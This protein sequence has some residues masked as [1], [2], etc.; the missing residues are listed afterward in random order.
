MSPDKKSFCYAPWHS[1]Y[2]D[3]KGEYRAC[4]ISHEPLGY[5]EK[6]TNFDE[7]F[8]GQ[9]LKEI[10]RLFLDGAIPLSCRSCYQQEQYDFKSVRQYFTELIE[11]KKEITDYT[12][13][14]D[15]ESL[16]RLDLCLS[17][18]CNLACEYCEPMNSSKRQKLIKEYHETDPEFYNKAWLKNFGITDRDYSHLQPMVTYSKGLKAI[19]FKGGEPLLAKAHLDVLKALQ[20]KAPEITLNYFTNGSIYNPEI[21]DL[22]RSFKCVKVFFSI[23]AVGELFHYIRAGD[24]SLEKHVEPN[25][26]K[27]AESLDNIK[28][29]VHNTLSV[30]NVMRLSEFFQWWRGLYQQYNC[31]LSLGMVSGPDF[32]SLNALPFKLK[33]K[34]IENIDNVELDLD[35][36]FHKKFSDIKNTISSSKFNQKSL[37][38]L[39]YHCKISE[40]NKSNQFINL[41]PEFQE[42]WS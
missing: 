24:Y 18:I 22:W 10:R 11:E 33:K 38:D 17:N 40:R 4:C 6:G 31:T 8:N 2:L 26:R 16:E 14:S 12:E 42:Y 19:D 13:L 28:L 41:V 39:I 32:M 3:P 34:A 1:A 35:D 5:P 36:H 37:R 20:N 27:Y 15:G 7:I 21:I 25:M 29:S 30:F 23:D 9:K